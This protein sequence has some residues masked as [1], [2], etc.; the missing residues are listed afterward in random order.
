M[1]YIAKDGKAFGNR[2]MGKHY[3]GSRKPEGEKTSQSK[4]SNPESESHMDDGDA[5][6]IVAEHGPAHHTEITEEDDGTHSVHSHHEDGHHHVS[7]G[8]DVHSAHAHSMHMHT[9]EAGGME[10]EEPDGDEGGMA[11]EG[12]PAIPGMKG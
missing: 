5:H 1:A 8:H 2:E 6:E 9:G 10:H 7:K 3:D 12:L 11:E 4:K